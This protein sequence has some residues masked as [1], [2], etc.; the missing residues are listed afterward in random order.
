M[1]IARYRLWLDPDDGDD[2]LR[3][4]PIFWDVRALTAQDA[5]DQFKVWRGDGPW[6]TVIRLEPVAGEPEWPVETIMVR[7]G[8]TWLTFN[9]YLD[10]DG[11]LEDL[12]EERA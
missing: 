3:G 7:D 11:A 4:M 12:L 5:L 2:D 1:T 8:E 9:D 10:L 6:M